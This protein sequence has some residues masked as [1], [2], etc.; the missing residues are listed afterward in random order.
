MEGVDSQTEKRR[1]SNRDYMR[2]WRS[3]PKQSARQRVKRDIWEAARKLRNA[4]DAMEPFT[5]VSGKL[6]CG[7]C[8]KRTPVTLVSR[9]QIGADGKFQQVEIPY[10]GI[11]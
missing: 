5:S 4:G 10:C 7:F 2:A 6:I 9:L 3:S 1:R 11:C 8:G